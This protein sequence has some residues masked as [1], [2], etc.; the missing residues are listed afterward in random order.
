[1][2][3]QSLRLPRDSRARPHCAISVVSVR[4]T[5]RPQINEYTCCSAGG[6]AQPR[7][8]LSSHLGHCQARAPTRRQTTASQGHR[9]CLFCAVST[10]P[11]AW[12]PSCQPRQSRHSHRTSVSWP[13]ISAFFTGAL[14]R[15]AMCAM[16][17]P[18]P[19]SV[20]VAIQAARLD[21][22]TPITTRR[23]CI[24][25]AWVC[26]VVR[27]HTH[28]SEKKAGRFPKIGCLGLGFVHFTR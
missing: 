11:E 13:S 24:K 22:A 26:R 1:M 28:T 2:K 23:W 16:H 18:G 15:T 6:G 20:E 5:E 14:L 27:S 10:A 9:P 19:C 21:K 7:G 17:Q 8:L 12:A 25:H 3:S 4:T